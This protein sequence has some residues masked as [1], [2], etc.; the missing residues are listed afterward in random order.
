M[1]SGLYTFLIFVHVCSVIGLFVAIGLEAAAIFR[2]GSTRA[3]AVVRENLSTLAILEKALPGAVGLVLASGLSMVLL[4]WGWT[5]AWIA[6]ALLV[7][8]LLGVLGP[9]VTGRRVTR[10]RS[11]SATGEH[12]GE[13]L[14]EAIVPLLGDPVLL[15]YAP[16][17][18]V[19][20]SP[21]LR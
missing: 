20:G 1:T 9:I 18:L 4:R 21:S 5:Q 19:M 15:G 2:L 6:S 17:P 14:P 8:V 7:L 12:A 13:N 10:I 16:V 11:A 3:T